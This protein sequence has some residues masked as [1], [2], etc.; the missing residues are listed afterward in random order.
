M[1]KFLLVLQN[2]SL[3]VPPCLYS[4]GKR[5]VCDFDKLFLPCFS[6]SLR[7]SV[8]SLMAPDTVEK[9]GLLRRPKTR[10]AVDMQAFEG[11]VEQYMLMNKGSFRVVTSP[12]GG[13]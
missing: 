13:F 4:E 5:G 11:G 12:L 8:G 6:R 7:M 10:R 9:R 1:G 3:L 2:V